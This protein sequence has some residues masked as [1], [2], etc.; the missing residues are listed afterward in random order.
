MKI[1]RL[2]TKDFLTVT[3]LSRD[4]ILALFRLSATL[5]RDL[6]MGKYHDLLKKKSLAMI[7]EKN[8]TRTRVSFETGVT[9]LGGHALFLS[10]N[11]IQIGRGETIEDTAKVLSRYVDC[12]MIRTFSQES[13]IQLAANSQIPVINGLTDLLHPCQAMA[14]FFTIF[15]RE[16]DL[17]K[18]RFTYIGDG[19]NMANSLLLG[20]AIL[21]IPM[22]FLGPDEYRPPEDIIRQ[23][24][25]LAEKSG[26]DIRISSDIDRSLEGTNYLYTDVWISMGQENDASAQRKK[27]ILSPYRITKKMLK[28]CAPRCRVMHCLPAHRGE[29]IDEEVL[30]SDRSIV[31]EQAENRMHVQKAILCALMR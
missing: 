30:D 14:D 13:I 7:F 8:S 20:S 2:K 29:E 18:V 25:E 17:G 21:G 15:E 19:N 31:Y 3:D 16:K 12:I 6:K 9:Q 27:E 5:K 10:G 28:K 4:E 24:R 11:D 26:S 1:P 22:T 23:A